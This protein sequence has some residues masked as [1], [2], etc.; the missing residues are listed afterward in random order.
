MAKQAEKSEIEKELR[1]GLMLLIQN[2]VKIK[3]ITLDEGVLDTTFS[4]E[5][6][7]VTFGWQ[8]DFEGNAGKRHLDFGEAASAINFTV[9]DILENVK[10]KTF[11]MN[12]EDG[13]IQAHTL[14]D[15]AGGINA[16]LKTVGID[17]KDFVK[18]PRQK[19]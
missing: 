6:G 18:L 16:A 9:G 19:Q 8:V 2:Q 13:D 14:E 10:Y 3:G 7:G 12:T 15:L 4:R 11:S 1:R 17:E 5:N